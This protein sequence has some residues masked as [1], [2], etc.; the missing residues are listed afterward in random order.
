[1]HSQLVNIAKKQKQHQLLGWYGA[2]DMMVLNKQGC[3][4][5]FELTKPNQSNQ[6]LL[7]P[8][9]W[10]STFSVNSGLLWSGV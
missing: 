6:A 10:S 8:W 7:E 2:C 3:R 1:M 4:I 9:C 5:S